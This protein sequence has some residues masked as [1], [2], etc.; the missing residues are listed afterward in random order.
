MKKNSDNFDVVIPSRSLRE[1]SA[2]FTDDIEAVEIFFAN[3]QILFR[4]ENISFYTRL[5]EGNYPDTD[6]LIPT[7][8]NT[9]VTFDVV[10]YVNL[11]NVLVSYQVLLKMEL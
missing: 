4:S 10:I 6:R 7:D 2:V 8:F 9:T 11:W 3:N 5:L 1:F